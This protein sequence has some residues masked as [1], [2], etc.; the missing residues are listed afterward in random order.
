MMN[1]KVLFES[2]CVLDKQ[3]GPQI[4]PITTS[5]SW[6]PQKEDLNSQFAKFSNTNEQNLNKGI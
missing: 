5:I 6:I 2:P 3:Y 4:G 1:C